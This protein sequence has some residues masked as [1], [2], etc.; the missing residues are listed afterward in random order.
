MSDI[1]RFKC[2]LSKALEGLDLAEEQVLMA[3]E[4]GVAVA[5]L[6]TLG[7]AARNAPILTGNLRGS[8]SARINGRPVGYTSNSGGTTGMNQS[9]FRPS[10]DNPRIQGE[11]GFDCEYAAEQHE[12]MAYNHPRGGKAKYLEDVLKEKAGDYVEIIGE[13]V[14]GAL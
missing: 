3:A 9:V 6:D 14:R 11:V 2:D 5:V 7:E 1:L 10:G 4:R 8:G 13:C 12:V